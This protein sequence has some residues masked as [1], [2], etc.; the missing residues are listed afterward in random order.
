MS[1]AAIQTALLAAPGLPAEQVWASNALDTP[2][3]WPFI[4]HRWDSVTPAFKLIGTEQVIIWV[5][6]KPGSYD[7]INTILEWVKQELTDMVHVPGSDGRILTCVEWT[8]DSGD[9]YDDGW[10]TITRNASFTVVS[11]AG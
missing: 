4:I 9:L 1:R 8:G 7:R 11:R 2:M 6:D 3:A 5:H 10:D